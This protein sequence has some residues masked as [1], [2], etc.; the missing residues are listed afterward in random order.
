MCDKHFVSVRRSG[1]FGHAR[2]TADRCVCVRGGG[3]GGGVKGVKG[4]KFSDCRESI[5]R[6]IQRSYKN[7]LGLR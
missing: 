4:L 2:K 6:Q 1:D 7:I 5:R 3:G